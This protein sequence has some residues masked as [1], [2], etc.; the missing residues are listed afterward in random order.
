M[1]LPVGIQW[2]IAALVGG[3]LGYLI[4][5]F[6]GRSRAASLDSRLEYELREQTAQRETELTQTR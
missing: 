6:K 2:L 1:N 3:A 5:W 4:G